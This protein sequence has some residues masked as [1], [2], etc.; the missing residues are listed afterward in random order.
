MSHC[1]DE[2]VPPQRTNQASAFGPGPLVFA[3]SSTGE[4][5]CAALVHP[6][7]PE[8]VTRRRTAP[9][10]Q[11]LEEAAA[12][13]DEEEGST[14]EEDGEEAREEWGEEDDGDTEEEDD[15]EGAADEG[16]A[17]VEVSEGCGSSA[18]AV[19]V[20]S[21]SV[22]VSVRVV[23]VRLGRA[24]E[25]VGLLFLCALLVAVKAWHAGWGIECCSVCLCVLMNINVYPCVC[26]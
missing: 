7:S 12:A 24:G 1:L 18:A 22:G 2:P 13:A 20:S 14:E 17:K 26:L 25:G 3:L 4:L 21:A 6:L 8:V 19:D 9:T 23:Q 16:R 10:A 5:W 15:D 11:S